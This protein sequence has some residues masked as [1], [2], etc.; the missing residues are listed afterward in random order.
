MNNLSR[1]RRLGIGAV[2][3]AALAAQPIRAQMETPLLNLTV[4]P[5]PFPLLPGEVVATCYSGVVN[6]FSPFDPDDPNLPNDPSNL[7]DG[8]GFVVAVVDTRDPL[9][10]AAVPGTHW[11]AGMFHNEFPVGA[12]TWN[13]RNL[14]QV[15]G[16][17]L[18][19]ANPPN[20]Y[21]AATTTFGLFKEV[22]NTPALGMFGPGGP[23]GVYKLNGATGAISVFASLPNSGP[24]LGDVAFDAA[25]NQFFVTNFDDGLIY[26]LSATGT[27]LGTFNHC[28]AAGQSYND[29]G[30]TAPSYSSL[31]TA[32]ASG[33]AAKGCRPWA[34]QVFRG[35]LYYSLWNHD[36]RNPTGTPNQIWSV[37][38]GTGGTLT[39]AP[40]KELDV[41]KAT[42]TGLLNPYSFPVSDIAFSA[43]GNLL[44]AERNMFS[45]DVG[46]P[47]A[48]SGHHARVLEY[49]GPPWVPTSNELH[50]GR[51]PGGSSLVT[52]PT[53]GAMKANSDGGADYNYEDFNYPPGTLP[54]N[55]D[56]DQTVWASAQ[57]ILGLNSLPFV[58]GLTGIR[59]SGNTL[60]T[61]G[62]ADYA[63]DL[64]NV[65]NDTQDK[66][67]IGDVEAYRPSCRG[68]CASVADIHVVCN[69]E[70]PGGVTVS[71]QLTNLTPDVI[72]HAFVTDLPTGVV[73]VFGDHLTFNPPI[74]PGQSVPISL[75][76]VGPVFGQTFTFTLSIHNENL[77]RCCSIPVTVQIPNCDCGQLLF[78][79]L[80]C[81]ADP[82]Q[83][84]ELT[85]LWQHLSGV[86]GAHLFVVPETGQNLTVTPAVFNQSL[87]YGQTVGGTLSISGLD[88]VPGAEICLL[89]ATH[90]EHFR[91]CCAVEQ[92]FTLPS[93]DFCV[94]LPEP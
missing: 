85:F 79:S 31:N 7:I 6:R 35:R 69:T 56:C 51:Y 57:A 88:A 60:V 46:S 21:V 38:I 93:T 25:N 44:L 4:S 11:P 17:T 8:N 1:W 76:F 3:A 92:C 78:S 89:F 16:I 83:H 13:A 12:N 86:T 41:A 77:E 34:V 64:N 50:V 39:G 49:Q 53:Y 45:G 67:K 15:F 68:D 29:G 81:V 40:V 20:L 66:T 63:V 65:T 80:A 48:G 59:A 24:A 52:D 37:A 28:L 43:T 2:I 74:Q 75:T 90:D 18:D 9:G 84:F 62:G 55:R 70:R 94:F 23:G 33:F 72:Y 61:A 47:G 71:F 73:S 36:H 30:P 19:D 26:R 91:E 10:E 5:A 42:H 14:G 27:T 87:V 82:F 22:N 58:Y 54:E 32:P